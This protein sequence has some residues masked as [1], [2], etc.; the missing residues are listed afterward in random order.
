MI[1]SQD[2]NRV[3]N[4][5]S[6]RKVFDITRWLLVTVAAMFAITA[7]GRTTYASSPSNVRV[8]DVRDVAAT[9]S[10]TSAAA[11]V[12]V[13][14][15]AAAVN[16]SCASSAYGTSA[17][18][19]RGSDT[20]STVHYVKLENLSPTTLYC[21]RPVSGSVTGPSSTF[22]TGPTLNLGASIRYTA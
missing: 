11:E 22:T 12:G 4:P 19:V 8:T 14:Q 13:V 6:I 10:W 21:Y 1:R 15:Y 7:G 2:G 18:D 16:G 5:V 3:L 20:A 9:V 17:I